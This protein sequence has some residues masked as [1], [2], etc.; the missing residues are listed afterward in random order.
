MQIEN[1]G[2]YFQKADLVAM[3]DTLWDSHQPRKAPARSFFHA[4]VGLLVGAL[5]WILSSSHLLLGA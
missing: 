4:A 2:K 5:S 3:H 1:H